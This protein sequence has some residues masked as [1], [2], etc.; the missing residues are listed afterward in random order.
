MFQNRFLLSL[1]LTLS[2]VFVLGASAAAAP[3]WVPLGKA[4]AADGSLVALDAAKPSAMALTFSFGGLWLEELETAAGPFTA[5]TL[6]G[7]AGAGEPGTPRLPVL[8]RRVAVPYGGPV[9]VTAL[10]EA[11]VTIDLAVPLAPAQPSQRKCD[12]P[13]PFAFAPKAYE[14]LAGLGPAARLLDVQTLRGV[15]HALVE[16]APVV[17]DPAGP[18]LTLYR[19]VHVRVETQGADLA[20]TRAALA[21]TLP[22]LERSVA[23]QV[24]GTEVFAAKGGEDLLHPLHYVLV[25]ADHAAQNFLPVLEPLVAWKEARG[26]HVTVLRTSVVGRTKE[27]IK[28]ALRALY[29]EPAAGVPAPTDVVLVGDVQHIPYWE[30]RGDGETQAADLYYATMDAPDSN[31][32]ADRVADFH[33]G[34]FS[35]ATAAELSTVV[36][37]TLAHERPADPAAAWFTRS[38]WPASDDHDA[39]A[40]FTHEWVRP[41]FEA[42]GMTFTTAYKDRIGES[43]A[44]AITHAA[45][46]QGQS[47]V[48]YSGH[49]GHDSWACIPTDNDDVHALPD[50]GAYPFVITNACQTGQFQY[51]NQGDCFSEA[52]LKAAGGAVASWAASNNSLWDEDDLIEKAVWAAF[53]P[54]LRARNDDPHMA[55]YPWPSGEAYTTVGAITNM[56]LLLF[57]ER[58]DRSWS[59]QYAV[60]EYNVLGDPSVAPWTQRPRPV[61]LLAPSAVV[62]GQ[63]ELSLEVHVGG[64]PLGGALVAVHKEGEVDRAAF[65]A[66]DGSVVVPLGELRSPGALRV[67]VT[68]HD[69]YPLDTELVVVPPGGAYVAV[70]GR[71]WTD[72]GAAGTVG[73]GNGLASPGETLGLAVT[74]KNVGDAP[75]TEVVATLSTS[76][77]CVALARDTLAVGA[78]GAGEAVAPPQP[79]LVAVRPCADDHRVELTLTVTAAEGSWAQAVSLRVRNALGGAV[80]VDR[81]DAPLEGATVAWDGPGSGTAVVDGAGRFLL[82]G[83]PAG[84]YRLTVTHPE[85]L[86]IERSVTIPAAAD[87]TFRLG[88]PELRLVPEALVASLLPSAGAVELPLLISNDG[89][90]AL[91]YTVVTSYANGDDEF[92][93]RWSDS[94]S[95]EVASEWVDVP[96]AARRTL[97]LS[98]D[99]DATV[100]LPFAFPFYGATRASVRVGAN[101]YVNFGASA[102]SA[103]WGPIDLPSTDAPR[104][105]VAVFYDDLDPSRGGSVYTGQVGDAF[106]VTWDDVPEY[107]WMGDGARHT[108]QLVLTPF[109]ELRF[110]YGA[111]GAGD[112]ML[113]VQSPD[114]T[115]GMN[116]GATPRLGLTVA[117]G[118]SIPFLTVR[119]GAGTLVPVAT[120][121]AAVI[122]DPTSLSPGTHELRLRVQSNDP[123]RGT[124]VL[125]LTLHVGSVGDEDGDGHAD[126][127]DNC[128]TVWNPDQADSD[129]DGVGD[130]CASGCVPAD[131]DDGDPCT[132]DRCVAAAC[133][134]EPLSEVACDDGDACTAGDKCAAGVCSGRTRSC[135]DANPC[136]ADAC[137][138][139]TGCVYAPV[140]GF[141][142]DGDACTTG[143]KCTNGVCTGR[144]MSCDDDNPCTADTCAADG[145]VFT[146]NTAACDDG[147]PCTAN[148]CADGA[149]VVTGAV[150]GCCRT[151]AD[152]PAWEACDADA[153]RCGPVQCQPCEADAD[154]ALAGA[155]CVAFPSGAACAVT[156][157]ADGGCPDGAACEPLEDGAEACLPS[158]GDCACA[159]RTE[160]RCLDGDLVWFDSCGAAG[161]RAVDCAGRGCA[162]GDCCAPGA[163]AE[164]ESCVPD[165][166]PV[167][168]APDA[169]GEDV[170]G[171]DAGEDVAGPDAG[172]DVA[173]PGGDV[174]GPGDDV[175]GPRTDAAGGRDT[176]GRPDTSE[177][178]SDARDP[179]SDAAGPDAGTTGSG[180]GSGGCAAAP[181]PPGTAPGA[182]ALLLVLLALAR[183][184]A[185]RRCRAAR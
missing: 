144:R 141:C 90:R 160:T 2:L 22:G 13:A 124:V 140:T 173:G 87:E 131:C 176:A 9:K 128:P 167:E 129:G 135:N 102:P 63:P 155:V 137:D 64:A 114:A 127:D 69:L 105:L 121:P 83:L 104:G 91:E 147:D 45:L 122:V 161:E 43:Q 165:E 174:A 47:I 178:R 73:D 35:V 76:D 59:I 103:P 149:C 3:S 21:R 169:G 52:W 184:L 170:A 72:D 58:A 145:C 185:R 75:A 34:R 97:S 60:E 39:L 150:A 177:P 138:P 126:A 119:D 15:R 61:E 132:A 133:T 182:G 48:N 16:V 57:Q 14:D 143:D 175:M 40:R 80:L 66:P 110:N 20:R 136:T 151:T 62:L 92:G 19:T 53:F 166:T 44:V 99:G 1:G 116:I 179:S 68:G 79:F 107:S 82:Y 50:T 153:G 36:R 33:I 38:L 77:A 181:P 162:E 156:C 85:Y 163:H 49:G 96:T 41:A 27:Q 113:G 8:R 89:D 55:G 10:R 93:Y 112:G 11:P 84:T 115:S 152:C 31:Y 111:G 157:D 32:T 158:D 139:A 94:D 24:L 168:P 6:T 164:G 148:R 51:N 70:T 109:G 146:P 42:A 125:P 95:G 65:S 120:R 159:P 88:R 30:G 130:A 7:G 171:P 26:F 74:L 18:S 28:A 154:C 123:R 25:V 12:A 134:H 142:D 67:V 46:R 81:S 180:G 29:T 17:F 37:K 98:D 54:S 78:L 5:A 100:S 118:T 101:G 108:F 86:P 4:A 183:A 117:V 56:G 106:V 23:A 71:R 172:E